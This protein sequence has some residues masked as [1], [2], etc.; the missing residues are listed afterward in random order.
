MDTNKIDG[1][2]MELID[3]IGKTKDIQKLFRLSDNSAFSIALH[4]ILVSLYEEDPQQLNEKQMNLFLSMHLENSGQSCGILSCMQEWFPQHLDKF[5]PA[6][7]AINAPKSANAIVKA[8]SL[9]P[10]DGSSFFKTSNSKTEH[11]LSKYDSEFS[12]YPD[13]NMPELYR[14]YAEQN[15]NEIEKRIETKS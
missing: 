3:E 11:L 6:L 1:F 14:K 10:K 15:R 8:I 13:G 5:V 7:E 9:L 4:Q 12:D 2:S